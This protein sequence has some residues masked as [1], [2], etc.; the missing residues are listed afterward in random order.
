MQKKKKESEKIEEMRK[1]QQR[2]IDIENE[3]KKIEEEKRI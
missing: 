2:M 3:K 1:L